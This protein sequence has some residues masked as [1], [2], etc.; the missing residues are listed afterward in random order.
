MDKDTLL[1]K[2]PAE[3]FEEALP[4][5]NGSL[6]GMVYGGLECDKISLN[7]DTLCSG[8]PKR[9]VK[10]NAYEGFIK[11]RGNILAG[12]VKEAE[13]EYIY[14]I[15]A[16]WTQNYLPMG[17]LYIKSDIKAYSGYSRMLDMENALVTVK[18]GK[19][20]REYFS[21][22]PVDAI[23]IKYTEE[24]K[25]SY[26]LD[27]KTPLRYTK[28]IENNSIII[29]GECPSNL[30]PCDREAEVPCSYDGNSIKFTTI[31]KVKTDGKISECE[32][33]L[34]ITDAENTVFYICTKTSF[35]D[36]NTVP[37]KET[38]NACT[39]KI[40]EVYLKEYE[41]IKENHIKDFSKYYNRC[42]IDLY[43]ENND[44]PT[45][46]MLKSGMYY[47]SLVEKIFG[48]A[49]Y[50][51]IS[52]S[53]PGSMAMNLQ[54]I[55]NEEFRPP[56]CSNYTLN[57][58]TEMN[59]WPANSLDLSEMC[60]PLEALVQKLQD[61]GTTTAKEYYNAPG[62]VAHHVSDIW[63]MST[64]CGP[65]TPKSC[66]WASW[67]MSVGWLLNNL[68]EK[69]E[70]TK[71]I[72]YLE[73]IYPLMKGFV[74]F[75]E[76]VL[77][78]YSGK[79]IMFPATSPENSYILDG[80][81]FGLAK[82]T[83]VNQSIL[84]EVFENYVKCCEL[85]NRDKNFKEKI[86]GIIPL[87]DTFEVGSK[88]QLL[89]WDEEYEESDETHRHISHLYGV[90]PGEL[91]TEE[92]N[93]KLYEAAKKSL[94]IRSDAG[95]GWSIAW[96]INMWA[97]FKDGNH[98]YEVF[99]K[100]LSYVNPNANKE[101]QNADKPTEVKTQDVMGGTYPNLFDA[102][103]PFQ[104]DGNFGV[105][106]GI[107]QWFLQCEDNRIKILP[108]LPDE[109][110]NGKLTG[111]IAKGNIKLDIEW[112]DGKCKVL[113]AVSPMDQEAVFEI[114]KEKVLV[115]LEKCVPYIFDFNVI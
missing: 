66:W 27:F 59:Y 17:S 22:K 92:K 12:N 115:R 103:P 46:E 37:D 7:H 8:T 78:E 70:Y 64:P 38:K 88:G 61:T 31:I 53:R 77:V 67:N 41:E 104:I 40:E 5:G 1:Y 112:E 54:G 26:E 71:D 56:W 100:Q 109:L 111:V 10:P 39:Q 69:Y 110:K 25:T 85:L 42:D 91:F 73:K 90:F 30:F 32:D 58:N 3:A 68:F 97:K 60:E 23:I 72:S 9:T 50:L 80:E 24:E 52:A 102:H 114:N 35:I 87:L 15:H 86:K 98:S 99:K 51:M 21:S 95:T 45:D 106:M 74:E 28:R 44:I 94:E 2:N 20:T 14:K 65:D 82:Y 16:D 108:A 62:F 76:Y 113:K 107:I 48:Y 89:E 19:G 11:S 13:E 101:Y 75:C 29:N 49:K 18:Y 96:K 93:K 79:K 4:V 43:T 63:G 83:T 81:E 55:W 6:G 47:P 34:K 105:A 36:Y 33:T 84:I 57:I